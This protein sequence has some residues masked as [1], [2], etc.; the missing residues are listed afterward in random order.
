VPDGKCVCCEERLTGVLGSFAWGIVNG[1]GAC[2]ACGWPARAYHRKVG[3]IEFFGLILQ[4][5]PDTLSEDE[6]S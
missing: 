5:H 6:G 4:Y 3:G 2:A 1:E